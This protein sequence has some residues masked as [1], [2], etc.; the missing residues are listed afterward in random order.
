MWCTL[1]RWSLKQSGLTI[2]GEEEKGERARRKERR[3]KEERDGGGG[4]G[5]I[6]LSSLHTL[7][8]L[9]FQQ[10]IKR[11][12]EMHLLIF[13]HRYNWWVMEGHP[14]LPERG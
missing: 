8:N 3:E 6:F 13:S 2:N 7:F 5:S 4:G 10:F 12:P 14:D 1:L 9:G 11:F